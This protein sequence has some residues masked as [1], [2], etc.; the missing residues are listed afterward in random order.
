[1]SKTYRCRVRKD[2]SVVSKAADEV[3]YK[4]GLLDI[5][6]PDEMRE[7]YR[8]S[9]QALGAQE[10]KDGKF[11]V[12]VAGAKVTVDPNARS[13]VAEVAEKERITV[14][15]DRVVAVRNVQDDEAAAR[16]EAERRVGQ[17]LAAEAA[18][19][20]RSHEERVRGKLDAAD[21][22]VRAKLREAAN[23]AHKSALRAKA[24]RLGKV[25]ADKEETL[26]NGDKR[27]TLEVEL[28]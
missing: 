27:V 15:T 14:S 13:A 11:V 4:V 28:E 25:M 10:G 17:E 2:V 6:D 19:R 7:H 12:E 9:L 1:V 20:K 23:E 18:K 24:D 21:E 16:Q 26:A 22:A 8:K 3:R 5:L